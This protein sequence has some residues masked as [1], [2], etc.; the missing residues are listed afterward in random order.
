MSDSPVAGQLAG[1]QPG[2]GVPPD[3]HPG[4]LPHP[5]GVWLHLLL[6]GVSAS[7]L[8]DGRWRPRAAALLPGVAVL[9]EESRVLPRDSRVVLYP[10]GADFAAPFIVVG[11]VDKRAAGSS[12]C[13]PRRITGI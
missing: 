11:A 3:L 2:S 8:A 13:R 1:G 10:A 9:P 12:T 7:V 5:T 6:I 4:V